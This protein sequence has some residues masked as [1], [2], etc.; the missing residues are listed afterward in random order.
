MLHHT[1]EG[2]LPKEAVLKSEKAY[3]PIFSRDKTSVVPIE[4][5]GAFDAL[6]DWLYILFNEGGRQS[7]TGPLFTRIGKGVR[8]ARS[9]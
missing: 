8:S 1:I 3:N 5:A 2:R 6:A 7:M 4:D 9:G